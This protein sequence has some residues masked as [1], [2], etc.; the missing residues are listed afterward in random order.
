MT[1][2]KLL[3]DGDFDINPKRS[4]LYPSLLVFAP[5]LPGSVAVGVAVIQHILGLAIIVGIGWIV[6]QM[7][8]LP[9]LW[10]PLATVVAAVWPRMLWQEHVMTAV[11]IMLTSPSGSDRRGG[12]LPLTSSLA[13]P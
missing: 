4:F 11:V 13:S 3:T 7:T 2:S 8:R 5:L 10:V 6:A 12:W 9:V 1:A